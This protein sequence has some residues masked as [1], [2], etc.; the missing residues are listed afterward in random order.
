MLKRIVLH[1]KDTRL[2]IEYTLC[3]IRF[4]ARNARLHDLQNSSQ[5]D[6]AI[7]Y[8]TRPDVLCQGNY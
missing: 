2:Q 3:Y 1:S 6:G 7:F 4:H 5:N 8:S